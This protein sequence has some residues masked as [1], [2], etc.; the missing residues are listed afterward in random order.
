MAWIAMIEG[1]IERTLD[2][3]FG[4]QV[5]TYGETIRNRGIQQAKNKQVAPTTGTTANKPI[6]KRVEV[7][8][9]TE[10]RSRSG[11]REGGG[12]KEGRGGEDLEPKPNSPET[13]RTNTSNCKKEGAEKSGHHNNVPPG[14]YEEILREARQRIDTR[15]LGIEG[16]KIRRGVTGSFILEIPGPNSHDKAD[17]F[18]QELRRVLMGREGVHVQRPT[19]MAELRL[20]GLDETIQAPEVREA[21]AVAGDCEE[22]EIQTGEIRKTPGGMGIVWLGSN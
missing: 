18:A 21:V 19:K 1:I 8:Q 15:R 9:K 7:V 13:H 10:S 17:K 14:T 2:K 12:E 4:C 22:E 16:A 11:S 3:R 6:V 20:R 5:P